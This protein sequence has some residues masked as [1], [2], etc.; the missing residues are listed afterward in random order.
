VRR[1]DPMLNL[2]FLGDLPRLASYLDECARCTGAW[3][4]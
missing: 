3:K 1:V 2:E 4:K